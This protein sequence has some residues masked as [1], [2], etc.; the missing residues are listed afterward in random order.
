MRLAIVNGVD[1][2]ASEIATESLAAHVHDEALRQQLSIVPRNL[3]AAEALGTL[4]EVGSPLEPHT[5]LIRLGDYQILDE[6]TAALLDS[7]FDAT[8]QEVAEQVEQFLSLA[9]ALAEQG[10]L[11]AAE[12][13]YRAADA[14]LRHE[15][16]ERRALLLAALADVKRRQG[17]LGEATQLLEEALS[18]LPRHAAML[19]QR[20]ALAAEG[21]E[22]AVVAAMQHRL[23]TLM[24]DAAE[25]RVALCESIA[26]ESLKAARQALEH[27]LSLRRGDRK[28]LQRLQR[29]QEASGDWAASVGIAVE[30]AEG[31]PSPK[32]RAR[33]LVAAAKSCSEKT[34]NT[35]RAVAIYEAAIE[36]DPG[37][38]EGF[39]AVEAELLRA[40]DHEGLASAYERQ[41]ARLSEPEARGALLRKLAEVYWQKLENNDQAI[42][43]LERL[44]ELLP[45]DPNARF[46]L[47]KLLEEEGNDYGAIRSLEVAASLAPRSTEIYQRLHELVSRSSS[48]DRTF[49]V[50]SVLVALGEAD[51]NHQLT[52]TQFAPEGLL[53]TSRSFDD[54][55]WAKFVPQN[56]PTEI[57]RIM[58]AIE[59][60]AM[61]YWFEEHAPKLKSLIPAEK[62]RINARRSTL[63]AVRCFSWASHLLNVDEPE[64][65]VEPENGRVSVATLPTETPALLLGRNVLSGRSMVE[66]S[67][68]ATHH[69]AYSRPAWRVLAFWTEAALL[70]ALLHAA[71]VLAKP[72]LELPL[73]EVGDRLRNELSDRVA[74]DQS[75]ALHEAVDSMLESN[76]KLDVVAWAR[77]VE[78]AACR[79]AL[80][81]S[82][83]VGVAGSVLAVAGAPLG[84][85]SAADR[86]RDLLPFAVSREFAALRKE[87]GVA[88]K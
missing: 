27:A 70:Q 21:G 29:V 66:L 16:T 46:A 4:L 10:Q 28:L 52:Y 33:A 54:G 34:K 79:I 73:G 65:Y 3:T 74:E 86:A 20:A 63:S 64:F 76:Q 69:L 41:I 59:P 24:P 39:S 75:E 85:E 35:A 26:S 87:F 51:I 49:L 88:V 5:L 40:G 17:D 72:E 13:H 9:R 67:F 47:A 43:A 42:D 61:S 30:L 32:A 37:V 11:D 44:I 83:D 45:D 12:N 22:S 58:A 25:A 81:A 57:D 14:F 36:D 18:I 60:A 7:N 2:G 80:L 8:E 1:P 55:T 23:L 31:I 84:G 77:S 53:Q 68:I 38:P 19:E 6:E 82:G 50:C 56:H 78:E 15:V 48:R 62:S 71:V